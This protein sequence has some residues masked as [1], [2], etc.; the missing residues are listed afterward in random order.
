MQTFETRHPVAHAADDMYALVA[1]VEDYPKFLPL[2]EAL[3]VVRRETIDSK[4]IL[5]ANMEVGY[6]LIRERFTS[7][8]TLDPAARSILVEYVDGPFK[9]LENRWCFEP[10]G[11][12][13]S[14]IDFFIAYEFRSR[15]FERLVGGLFDKAVRKYTDAFEARADQVYGAKRAA[16][17]T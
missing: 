15:M 12:G 7:R 13:G 8:V 14:E 9:H 5:T 17:T 6:K 4:E 11:T 16:L 3:T 10:R 1:N 2:C